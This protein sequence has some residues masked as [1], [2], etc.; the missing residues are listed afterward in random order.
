MMGIASLHPSYALYAYASL[1]G[2]RFQ[3]G[4]PIHIYHNPDAPDYS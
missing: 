3:P 2:R 1:T 4:H